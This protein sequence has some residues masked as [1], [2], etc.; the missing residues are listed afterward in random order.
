[1][2]CAA[3]ASRCFPS[4]CV[5]AGFTAEAAIRRWLADQ[6]FEHV[7]QQIVFQ[8]G[9]D[10]IEDALQCLRRLEKQLALIAPSKNATTSRRLAACKS[11]YIW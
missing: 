9:I 3:N 7:A 2:T 1:M 11:P 10:A 4:C 6:K 5:T 8:E